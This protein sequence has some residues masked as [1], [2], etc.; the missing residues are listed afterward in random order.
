MPKALTIAGMTD[1]PK[2]AATR[3]DAAFVRAPVSKVPGFMVDDLQDEP[4]IAA[5]ALKGIR[6]RPPDI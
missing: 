5:N 1:T 3:R 6:L 2:P 4:M